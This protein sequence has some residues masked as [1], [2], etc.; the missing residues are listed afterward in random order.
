MFQDV[1]VMEDCGECMGAQGVGLLQDYLGILEDHTI[2]LLVY[3]AVPFYFMDS[4]L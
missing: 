4:Y 1:G 3:R 2:P